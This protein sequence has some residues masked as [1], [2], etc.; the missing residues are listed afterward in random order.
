MRCQ[1]VLKIASIKGVKKNAALYHLASKTSR[2]K[3]QGWFQLKSPT[4]EPI[5]KMSPESAQEQGIV[6][7]DP[8]AVQFVEI[9]G[10]LQF[11]GLL[12]PRVDDGPPP[13]KAGLADPPPP[14]HRGTRNM[15]GSRDLLDPAPPPEDET[16]AL[17]GDL[18]G[19]EDEP[20][21]ID[22]DIYA[23]STLV[24]A[25]PDVVERPIDACGSDEDLLEANDNEIDQMQ[26]GDNEL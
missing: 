16:P 5:F 14:P 8:P 15:N 12:V 2:Y 24:L 23:S 18:E 20:Q 21:V 1:E 7:H 19:D 13:P 25:F 17:S 26:A 9:P 3:F 10:T 4:L 6:R 11:G 22:N